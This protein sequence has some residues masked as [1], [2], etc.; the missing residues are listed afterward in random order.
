MRILFDREIK[1]FTKKEGGLTYTVTAGAYCIAMFFALLLLAVCGNDQN[2]PVY[3][4]LSAF[5]VY[6]CLTAV[7]V[8]VV[9]D[10]KT[11]VKRFCGKFD[12]KYALLSLLLWFGLIFGLGRTNG[13]IV[14][15][16]AKIGLTVPTANYPLN[17]TV[18]Y[19]GVLFFAG[20]IPA[21]IEEF[22]FRG[23]ILSS[24]KGVNVLVRSVIIGALFMLFHCNL[25]QTI[26]QFLFGFA[27]SLFAVRS[28]SII[29]GL[30]MHLINNVFVV[31]MAYFAPS[32]NYLSN[33]VLFYVALGVFVLVF[34]YLIFFDKNDK[35]CG[36]NN[37]TVKQFFKA[38]G[39]GVAFFAVFL[40]ISILQSAGVA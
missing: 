20:I 25:S 1:S 23:V 19:L 12:I 18:Q 11:S 8:F 24:L 22:L 38:S 34:A 10:K 26:Y 15:G 35:L 39:I 17:N 33:D 6:A 30:V 31:S 29:Y 36:E 21:I 5:I 27:F 40:V 2:S 37:G 14:D 4:I 13:Y 9:V 32:V 28:G 7:A 3:K 16:L